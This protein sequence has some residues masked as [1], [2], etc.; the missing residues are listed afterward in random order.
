MEENRYG[1]LTSM[2][3]KQV[4]AELGIKQETV[5]KI[6]SI[7]DNI[8]IQQ[9]DQKTVIQLKLKDITIVVNK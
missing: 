1:G 9:Y 8:D 5:D 6:Q 2:I 7:V 4:M 3:I